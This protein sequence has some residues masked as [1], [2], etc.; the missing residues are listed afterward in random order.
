MKAAF[1]AHRVDAAHRQFGPADRQHNAGQAAA[2]TH[3]EHL[4]RPSAGV[5]QQRR[6]RR[7]AVE[8]VV[9]QHLLRVA[10]RRQ[11]VNPV[12]FLE[13]RQVGQ[14]LLELGLAQRQTE[15]G[16]AR[17]QRGGRRLCACAAHAAGLSAVSG[18]GRRPLK[19]PF[20]R[21]ISSREMVA[22]VMPEMREAWPR[23]SGRCLASFWRAS[24][25][26]AETCR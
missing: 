26:R 8:Q 13:Q 11:V 16:R 17:F 10:H 19:P 14:Q 22:G 9:G 7:Q 1:F 2:R 20:F 21:W 25:D 15:R 5:A 12:P 3:V 4:R 6:D 23:V 24:I 18:A